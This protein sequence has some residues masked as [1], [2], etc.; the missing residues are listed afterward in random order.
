MKLL[1][2]AMWIFLIFSTVCYNRILQSSKS[3]IFTDHI[4][5]SARSLDI[6]LKLF[7][8]GFYD[9]TYKLLFHPLS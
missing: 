3:R 8:V 1:S 9:S 5:Y 4:W 7:N 2:E 6:T